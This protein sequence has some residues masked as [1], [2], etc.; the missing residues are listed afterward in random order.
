MPVVAMQSNMGV[1][2]PADAL[3]KC[4][5]AAEQAINVLRRAS[6][7]LKEDNVNVSEQDL[8]N[9][10]NF[11]F[12]G[13]DDADF[14]DCVANIRLLI[15]ATKRGIAEQRIKVD[16]GYFNHAQRRTVTHIMFLGMNNFTCPNRLLRFFV[17]EASHMYANTDD[18]TGYLTRQGT[19]E[20]N[21]VNKESASNSADALAGLVLAF[22]GIGI[23]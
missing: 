6:Q 16:Y 7:T 21:G 14:G 10:A 3:T 4:Q 19:Y 17:H 9:L 2:I 22:S 20:N 15:K 23:E 5:A 13:Q 1:R 8:A 11:Y 18:R 12:I